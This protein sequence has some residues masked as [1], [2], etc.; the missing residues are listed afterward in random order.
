M[1]ITGRCVGRICW[2]QA[3]W[4]CVLD[5]TLNSYRGYIVPFIR[6]WFFLVFIPN[7]TL[8]TNG[9]QCGV[10]H[11]LG[12]INESVEDSQIR[13]QISISIYW[14]EIKSVSQMHY[15]LHSMCSTLSL[16]LKSCSLKQ[17]S[18]CLFLFKLSHN[19]YYIPRFGILMFVAEFR[20]CNWLNFRSLWK[21][22]L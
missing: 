15:Q 9:A 21:C 7:I 1:L 2:M 17:S 14:I 19:L 6:R 12:F 10:L 11:S 16:A 5:S 13:V 3:F 22:R 4:S 20:F 18:H 8:I